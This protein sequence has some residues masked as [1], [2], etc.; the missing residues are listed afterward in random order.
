[1]AHYVLTKWKASEIKNLRVLL[2]IGLVMPF[3]TA[4]CERSFSNM[5]RIKSAE[6]SK[7]GDILNSLMHIYSLRGRPDGFMKIK[8][9]C[10]KKVS[11][12]VAHKVWKRPGY[13]HDSYYENI[14]IV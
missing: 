10:F 14:F 1:M 6:R 3:A 9:D 4:D 8:K 7:L 12:T 5:N 11:E 13:R 2:S